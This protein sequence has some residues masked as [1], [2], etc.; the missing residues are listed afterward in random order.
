MSSFIPCF[1]K[2]L[3]VLHENIHYFQEQVIDG[4]INIEDIQKSAEYQTNGFTTSAVLHD[5]KYQFGS[6]YLTG[7]TVNGYYCYY[8][9]AGAL[10]NRI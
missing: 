1:L 8:K 7:E 4:A 6:Q 3:T 5:G 2:R 9:A 10:Y